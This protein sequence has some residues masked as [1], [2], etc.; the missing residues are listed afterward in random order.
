MTSSTGEDFLVFLSVERVRFPAE[1]RQG[2]LP[3]AN[4]RIRIGHDGEDLPSKGE[5]R[6]PGGKPLILE[7]PG[8]GGFGDPAAREKDALTQDLDHCLV[9]QKDAEDL[10]RGEDDT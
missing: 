2:G 3:G 1:G 4:G 10:Y 6:V 8:G 5:F 9:S 7:T